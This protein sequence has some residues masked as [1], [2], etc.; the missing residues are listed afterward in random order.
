MA[1]S[2]RQIVHDIFHLLVIATISCT[3]T[4]PCK[5]QK[6]QTPIN[7]V[8]YKTPVSIKFTIPAIWNNVQLKKIVIDSD[9]SVFVLTNN[10]VY[11]D[12]PN[13]ILAKDRI[14][15]SL[16]D[17]EPLDI[18]TQENTGCLYYLYS[19]RYLSNRHAGSIC[20]HLPNNKFLHIAV[21]SK[22]EVMLV[23]LNSAAIY[24]ENKE[25]NEITVPQGNFINLYAANNRFWYLTSDALY[26]FDGNSWKNIQKGK[27]YTA[28]AF[29]NNQIAIGT[30]NGYKIIDYKGL[31]IEPINSHLPNDSISNITNVNSQFWFASKN[32]AFV[33]NGTHFNFFGYQRWL[34]Q[35]EVIDIAADRSG[36]VYLLTKTGLNEIVFKQ[37]TLA[38]KA[39]IINNNLRKYHLRYGFSAETRLLDPNDPTSIRVDDSDNDGLW[40][41]FYLGSEAFR[42]AVTGDSLAKEHVWETFES[43][44]RLISIHSDS[45]FSS[46]SFER[47]GYVAN[48]VKAWRSSPDQDWWWKGTT[49]TDEFVGYIFVASVIDQFIAKTPSEKKRLS[50]YVDYIMNHIITHNYY[51]LD[52]D[53]KPTVWGR[54]NPDYVNSF[55]STQF[56]RRL[57]STLTIAGLQL[58][59]K[60]TRKEIYKKEAFRMMD[61]YGYLK[62]MENPM[63]NIKFTVGF[64]HL[65]RIIMGQ[66]WNHSDDEMAFLTYWVL[67]HYAFNQNLQKQYA[68]MIKDHWAIEKPEG[69]ALWNLISYGTCGSIDLKATLK[70]LREFPSD[71]TQYTVENSQRK[72]L[73]F[74]PSD[75]KTNFRNQTT[76]ELL[77]K[78]ERP[79]NRHNANEFELDSQRGGSSC[80]AGDEYL[81]PY[82]MARYLKVIK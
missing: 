2:G 65:G 32:G 77:P 1:K 3:I 39:E 56:D 43:Y 26:F 38:Q 80:L 19:D 61:K 13:S 63:E 72:D 79:M 70:Y 17:K 30:L 74:L 9:E 21:N 54:L 15:S 57:N 76:R 11:R 10:G 62:N 44:E 35:K 24:K 50:D 59:Y 42:Y 75:V 20:G 36:N 60:L 41:S 6:L 7:D 16:S 40:T 18:C 5:S 78:N 33:K 34:N 81:L 71:C 22:G 53:G 68:E 47:T 12:F 37:E 64:K 45:I 29:S 25:T 49:S 31:E 73:D 51:F 46:R 8:P 52:Y 27:D 69:D 67:Y 4:I 58:A 48:D 23:G 66:D 82:W 28:A 14:Y 55:A